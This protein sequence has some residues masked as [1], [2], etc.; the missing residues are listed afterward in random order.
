MNICK[1]NFFPLNGFD[2]KQKENYQAKNSKMHSY[3]QDCFK[4][5][6]SPLLKWDI[7][8]LT[9]ISKILKIT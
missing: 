1:S 6:E 2:N 4:L 9:Q 5:L 7:K 8:F 3:S